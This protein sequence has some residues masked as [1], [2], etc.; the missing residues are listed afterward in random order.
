MES[1]ELTAQ[2]APVGIATRGFACRGCGAPVARSVLDL[3]STPLANAYLDEA[4]LARPERKYPLHLFIC[5]QCLLV[6]LEALVSPEELFT[7]YAYFSSYSSTWLDHARRFAEMAIARFGLGT[8][9]EVIEVA[10]NDGYLLRNFVER[11]I[12]VLGIEPAANV[13]AVARANGVPTEVRFFG[14]ACARELRRR[15]YVADLIVANN[16]V[17]HVPD[18]QD[19]LSGVAELL[20]ADGVLAAEFPHLLHLLQQTQFDTIYHEHFSY[21]SLRA[22]ETVLAFAGLRA[23]DVETLPTHGGSLRLFACRRDSNR[24][25]ETSHVATVRAAEKAGGLERLE[26]YEAFASRVAGCREGLLRFIEGAHSTGRVVAAYGAA[27]KG[28]TLLNSCGLTNKDIACVADRS[29]HKQGRYLPGGRIP[30]V[31]PERIAEVRPDY[32]LVLPWNLRDE[33]MHDMAHVR[34]WGCRFAVAIP[35]IETLE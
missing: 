22:I 25:P 1:L 28:N 13:A 29:P 12:P 15:G 23:F 16:V 21:L 7:D 2:A 27:A 30:I 35:Q 18:L 4:A 34:D 20:K 26:T 33:I 10:S 8:A 31:A 19:F 3:G 17:A 5:E 11:A 6:Q 24:Y 14:M 32:L 9:S